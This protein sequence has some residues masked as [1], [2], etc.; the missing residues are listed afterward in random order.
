MDWVLILTIVAAVVGVIAGL[1]QVV[2]YFQDRKKKSL[3]RATPTKAP[4][5]SASDEHSPTANIESV[6]SGMS[7]KP[8][9]L[10]NLPNAEYGQ[11]IGRE[12]ELTKIH[13][14]LRP[15]PHSQHSIVTI[16]GIG[17]IGKSTL[18]LET[19]Y[20]YLRNAALL[21]EE[22]RFDAIIWTSAKMT[23]LTADGIK[24]RHQSFR[25]LSDIYSAIAITLQREDIIRAN[26]KD[27]AETVRNALT[28]QRTLIIIDNF[29]TIDDESIISFLQE[30]PAPTKAIVTTRHRVDVAY[31]IR[32]TEMSWEDTKDLITQECKK[33]NVVLDENESQKLFK[34]TGGIPLAIVWSIAQVGVGHSIESVL[35]RLGNPKNDV[36]LFCFDEI[37]QTL[38]DTPAFHLLLAMSLFE[39]D[40]DRR[41]I[42]EVTKIPEL[43]LDEGITKLE[44]LSL[45]NRSRGDRPGVQLRF[46]LLPLTKSYVTDKFQSFPDLY[47]EYWTN[48]AKYYVRW[49]EEKDS[50]VA[51][52]S[53][54]SFNEWRY[55]RENF[56]TIIDQAY[57]RQEYQ[58][59]LDLI[60]T[61]SYFQFALGYWEER[62][63]YAQMGI[64]VA[65]NIGDKNSY[66]RLVHDMAYMS[67][68]E[69]DL[70]TAERLCSDA[71]TVFRS[72]DDRWHLGSSL[73]L[74]GTIAFKR[75]DLEKAK[76]DLNE[77]AE[78]MKQ[79]HSERGLCIAYNT[80]A[81]IAI[82]EMDFEEAESL[83]RYSIESSKEEQHFDG[84]SHALSTM[85]KLYRAKGNLDLA[86]TYYRESLDYEERMERPPYKAMRMVK[87]A[88]ILLETNK[89]P[90]A[91]ALATAAQE[92]AER[93]GMKKVMDEARAILAK[94]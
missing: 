84:I 25:T 9:V 18:A 12:R 49:S 46:S 86:E 83:L 71:Q 81:S 58:L 33:K 13:E 6:E 63:R 92:I 22:D 72:L 14:I 94:I 52:R 19:A 15:Y 79:I 2:Q 54:E 67:H 34:R 68:T 61:A 24:A 64:T 78:I 20:Y 16:D 73:R 93:V 36:T 42:G 29:E 32:L 23:I 39:K 70:D 17:G 26:A 65:Q 50:L 47:K 37:F 31:P 88:A 55:E 30:L 41:A 62:N 57:V 10:H 89:K 51:G 75:G 44:K 38:K 4:V 59:F 66:A 40:S 90:E 3:G 48:L 60:L 8:L 53:I 7:Q 43:D 21:R 69:G 80:L 56:L 5:N 85:G 82:D 76:R 35:Q 45:V 91:F 77:D 1:V 27:Q 28:K 11:F 74:S 87:L